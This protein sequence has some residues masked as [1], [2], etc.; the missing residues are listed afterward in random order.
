MQNKHSTSSS[1]RKTMNGRTGAGEKPVFSEAKSQFVV[2][3]A[4]RITAINF[5]TKASFHVRCVAGEACVWLGLLPTY[6]FSKASFHSSVFFEAVNM[7]I[8]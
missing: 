8:V 5:F 7:K 6:W 3:S 1:H 4:L 2:G